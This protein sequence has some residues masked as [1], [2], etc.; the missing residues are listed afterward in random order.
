MN[1]LLQPTLTQFTNFEHPEGIEKPV[2]D[3]SDSKDVKQ[4][5]YGFSNEMYKRYTWSDY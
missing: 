2:D 5:Q 3:Y 1:D 4:A